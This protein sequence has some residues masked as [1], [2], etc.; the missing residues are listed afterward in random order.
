MNNNNNNNNDST[1]GKR[2]IIRKKT[3]AEIY[4]QALKGKNTQKIKKGNNTTIRSSSIS[5]PYKT[6]KKPSALD[7]ANNKV[8]EA[9]LAQIGQL[10]LSLGCTPDKARKIVDFNHQQFLRDSPLKE[11]K[12]KYDTTINNNNNNTTTMLSTPSLPEEY[13]YSCEEV[14]E[15]IDE[16]IE[17]EE[18][19]T[20]IRV[21]KRKLRKQ[22][23]KELTKCGQSSISTKA[24][25]VKGDEEESDEEDE[26]DLDDSFID[27]RNNIS[28]DYEAEDGSLDSD[29][30]EELREAKKEIRKL[31]KENQTLSQDLIAQLKKIQYLQEE[32]FFMRNKVDDL[33]SRMN[34][35]IKQRNAQLTI[36]KEYA[37]LCEKPIPESDQY[38]DVLANAKTLTFVEE[39]KKTSSQ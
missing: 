32:N 8:Q 4:Q 24:K 18:E 25:K 19:D 23:R 17:S 29:P 37:A 20:P 26:Y 2:I 16:D 22:D 12:S 11:K 35:I 10:V 36:L 6:P 28:S 39:E 5:S 9:K 31:R 30:E 34:V 33:E 13:E 27:N 15:D 3:K 21:S 14:P 1:T 7:Y 38:D